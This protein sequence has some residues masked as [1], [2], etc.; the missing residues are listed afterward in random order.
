MC[1]SVQ[2]FASCL[3]AAL[4]CPNAFSA[5]SPNIILMMADDMGMGDTSA[6]QEITGNGDEVQLHT[7]HLERL[8][9][10]GVRMTDAHTPSSRCSPTRYGLL[11]GRYPWRNR[12]KHWVLFGSQGD[13][14]IEAD[15][16][17]IA[18]M[19]RRQGFSTAMYGKWHVGLRYRRSDGS[20]ADGWQDADLKQPLL[21]TPV[22]HGFD[23]ARFTSRSHGTSGP[24]A[25]GKVAKKRNGPKQNVGPGHIHDRVAVGATDNGKQLVSNGPNAYVLT[26]LG[27]RHSD[28]AIDFLQNHVGNETTQSRPFFLYYPSNS[29]HAPYTAD[30]AIGRESVAGAARTKSGKSMDLRYDYVYENDV[31]LGRLMKWLE[32][33]DDPRNPGRKLI[34]TTL[35]IFTSDNGAEKNDD[36]ATGPFRSHKGSCYEGGHRVPF[37]A[38]WAA[39]GIG[40]GDPTTPGETFDAPIGLQDMYATFAE[41]VGAELPD[42]RSGQKGAEDSYSVLAALR[43]EPLHKRPP[44]F[45]NDHKE[46]EGDP[47]VAAVRIDSPT[48]DGKVYQGKWKLFFDA[49]LLR[50]GKA[51]PYELYDLAVDQWETD[52]L[53][54]DEALQPLVQFM[55]AQ[56]LL[57]RNAGGHRVAEFA[58]EDRVHLDWTV[59]NLNRNVDG[60]MVAAIAV[61]NNSNV[62]RATLR[63]ATKDGENNVANSNRT[64]TS[65]PDGIGI[66]GG[67]SPNVNDEESFLIQFDQDVIVESVAIV[68][69]TDGTCGG[70]YKVGDAAP[71][72]IYCIDADIDAKDQS[73]ILSDIGVL[74]AGKTLRLDSSPHYGVE[75]AGNWRFRSIT[76]RALQ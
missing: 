72:A 41:I 64:I 38:T 11:T 2:R 71:L 69:G 65:S 22:D 20:P 62:L 74:R 26:K 39:G 29:N 6:F 49:S 52:D 67:D 7:P 32:S 55:S 42:L 31:A 30:H 25:G 66:Q 45:F 16:P 15:R 48:V 34:E 40:D 28:H 9:R 14:M 59:D 53:I 27:S 33:T 63:A 23:S 57:H 43:G 56:A 10:M 61:R 50:A 44:L 24:D 73:G 19:L 46:A 12:L 17:T 75:S 68:A 51:N 21:T 8:A 58:P 54:D 35:L 18:T 70:F 37:I 76:V 1:R 13:P 3:I 60:K 47:A 36:V 4:L 5:E